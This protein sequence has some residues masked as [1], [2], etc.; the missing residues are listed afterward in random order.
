LIADGDVSLLP[1]MQASLEN[2]FRSDG[3]TEGQMAEIAELWDA[4]SNVEQW[5]GDDF[6]RLLRW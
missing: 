4:R 2:A 5:L 6:A 3:M 1:L